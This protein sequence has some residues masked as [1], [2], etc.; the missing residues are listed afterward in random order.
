MASTSKT[1]DTNYV[2]RGSRDD[3]ASI[4]KK[5]PREKLLEVGMARL[6]SQGN[7]TKIVGLY[8]SDKETW[9]LCLYIV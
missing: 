9:L 2:E 1:K 3:K 5:D 8:Q 4:D 6:C 7:W